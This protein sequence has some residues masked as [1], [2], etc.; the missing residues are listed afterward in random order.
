MDG[1]GA[2]AIDP[3]AVDGIER[4]RAVESEAARRADAS[5]G[6]GDGVEGF[7]GVKAD[8]DEVRCGLRRGHRESLAEAGTDGRKGINAATAESG[9]FGGEENTGRLVKKINA[10]WKKEERKKKRGA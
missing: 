2:L 9:E 1:R 10:T 3:L 8:I 6:N 7:D 4:P 5:L